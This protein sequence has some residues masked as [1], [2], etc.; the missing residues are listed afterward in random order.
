MRSLVSPQRA[1]IGLRHAGAA[2]EFRVADGRAD[3]VRVRVAMADDKNFAHASG[4]RLTRISD[5]SKRKAR[6]MV[7]FEADSP[8]SGGTR[9]EYQ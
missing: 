9:Q 6:W 4:G 2:L 8:G 3:R 1:A 5:G 7:Y